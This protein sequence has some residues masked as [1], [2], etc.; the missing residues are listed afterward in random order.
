MWAESV[1]ENAP[2]CRPPRAP[3]LLWTAAQAGYKRHVC[4]P[5]PRHDFFRW[6]NQFDRGVPRRATRIERPVTPEVAGSSPVAPVKVLQIGILSY[7]RRSDRPPASCDPAH[8][9]APENSRPG[10][11][12]AQIPASQTTGQVA[13]RPRQTTVEMRRFP[14]ALSIAQAARSADPAQVRRWRRASHAMSSFSSTS[15]ANDRIA[16]I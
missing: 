10:P 5:V 2:A 13:G 15:S 11:L 14:A 1:E 4:R 8:I 9:P 12:K 16:P 6:R 3:A 7:R